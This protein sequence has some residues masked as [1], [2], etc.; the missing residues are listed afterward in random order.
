[1]VQYLKNRREMP[2]RWHTELT[3]MTVQVDDFF[4]FLY[5]SIWKVEY[6]PILFQ[7]LNQTLLKQMNSNCVMMETV[8]IWH[9]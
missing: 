7:K 4:R 1:M 3:H 8:Y 9:N 2:L 6:F 5:S